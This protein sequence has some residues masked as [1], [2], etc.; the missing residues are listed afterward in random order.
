VTDLVESEKGFQGWIVDLARLRGWRVFHVLN[1][2]GSE[3]GWPDLALTRPPR[4]IAAEVKSA[5]GRLTAA[6]RD[7]LAVLA[8]CGVE[9]YVWRPADRPDIERTLAW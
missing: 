6:Q 8:A 5:T 4:F 3:P 9:T 7:M 2:K 1:S